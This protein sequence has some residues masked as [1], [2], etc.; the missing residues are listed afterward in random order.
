M[1]ESGGKTPVH[2]AAWKGRLENLR[3]LLETMECNVDVISTGEFSYGKTPI[4]FA[5]TQSREDVVEYLLERGACVK[6]VN[7]KGQ[8]P[9]SVASSHLSAAAIS[10]IEARELDQNDVEW[11]NYRA[12]HSD[13]L[14]YGD[15]D[16]R[17]LDRPLRGGRDSVTALA[18]NPTTK[19]IRRGNFLRNN[20]HKARE[21]QSKKINKPTRIRESQA[22]PPSLS[23]EQLQQL[24]SAWERLEHGLVNGGPCVDDL[25]LIIQLSVQR[26]CSWIPEAVSRLRCFPE[27]VEFLESCARDPAAPD[28]A[29]I[30]R[31]SRQVTDP[32]RRDRPCGSKPAQSIAQSVPTIDLTKDDRWRD[33]CQQVK[34]L[35][36]GCLENGMPCLS[37]R[38]SPTFV[39]SLQQ[40]EDLEHAL[41][42]ESL[43]AIDAEWH[44]NDSVSTLQVA[45]KDTA[46]VIDLLC[47]DLDYRT[48]CRAFVQSLFCRKS[49]ILLGFAA[50][51]DVPRLERY[52]GGSLAASSTKPVLDLQLLWSNRSQMPGLAA[53]AGKYSSLPL[54]KRQQCSDWSQRPLSREQLEYA[55][56]DAAVLPFLLAEKYK[57][58]MHQ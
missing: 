16:P 27:S 22:R 54:S 46:W 20:P 55:G 38:Q 39:D 1:A 53:C 29:L 18:I 19:Q 12:T 48:R 43:I 30:R 23:K 52:V 31:L 10:K 44:G 49:T 58:K 36:I 5:L 9:L 40:L 7:N 45:V 33:A 11:T 56:L 24:N 15:L 25:S 21:A 3:Y 26:R 8:S 34:D 4:F 42:L 14:E 41:A 2:M 50:G 35:S 32:T 37:L 47:S 28:L 57:R 6:I 13:G 17:F 51:H